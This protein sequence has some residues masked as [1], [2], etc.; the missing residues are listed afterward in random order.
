MI[1]NKLVMHYLWFL[2]I[3]IIITSYLY[4][5]LRLSKQIST[6]TLK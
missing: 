3:L 2:N 5:N 6:F 4:S 1:L